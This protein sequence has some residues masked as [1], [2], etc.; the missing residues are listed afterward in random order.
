[1]KWRPSISDTYLQCCISV[2][3]ISGTYSI[4]WFSCGD[5]EVTLLWS[6]EVMKLLSY[7]V[8]KLPR[9]EF[10]SYEVTLLWS[11]PLWSYLSL[12]LKNILKN[13]N[14]FFCP[15]IRHFFYSWR[16]KN[17]LLLVFFLFEFQFDAI[18]HQ[19]ILFFSSTHKNDFKKFVIDQFRNFS[20][21]CLLFVFGIENFLLLIILLN[22]THDFSLFFAF[23]QFFK[24][25]FQFFQFFFRWK[26]NFQ[27]FFFKI[28]SWKQSFQ[29]LNRDWIYFWQRIF[30][31]FW[32]RIFKFTCYHVC[33]LRVLPAATAAAAAARANEPR[34]PDVF[35]RAWPN[36]RWIGAQRIGVKNTFW[37]YKT[38]N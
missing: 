18:F 16:A 8:M 30:K 21:N 24:Q 15:E 29:I 5:D 19:R 38:F 22:F 25:F 35:S 14:V 13:R 12:R 20:S 3:T 9:C 31:I 17:F 37:F 27:N 26:R 34:P 11:Y 36:D 23:I 10:T 28:R 2:F 4:Y 7:E 33:K 6:Y 1:M 32:Q